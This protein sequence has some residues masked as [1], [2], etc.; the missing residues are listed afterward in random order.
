MDNDHVLL[1]LLSQWSPGKVIEWESPMNAGATEPDP[2][3]TANQI[4]YLL[5]NIVQ[6]S[7]VSV[8]VGQHLLTLSVERDANEQL[9]RASI[10]DADIGR[11]SRRRGPRSWFQQVRDRLAR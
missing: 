6:L 10:A 1:A 5:S 3:L 2:Y 11:V 7:S 9:V 8:L 4:D